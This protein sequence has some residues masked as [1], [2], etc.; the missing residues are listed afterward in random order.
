MRREVEVKVFRTHDDA[1]L[2]ERASEHAAGWDIRALKE[3][4]V[5]FGVQ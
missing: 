2:P 1:V 3:T 5:S 4:V